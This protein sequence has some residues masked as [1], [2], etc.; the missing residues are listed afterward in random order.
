MNANDTVRELRIA[1]R[2]L[3]VIR[4]Q[5][6]VIWLEDSV[7]GYAFSQYKAYREK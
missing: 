5:I 3:F 1:M 6:T 7:S 4:F 2:L